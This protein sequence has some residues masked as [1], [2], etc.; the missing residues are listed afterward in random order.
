MAEA[1]AARAA[2]LHRGLPDEITTWEILVRLP[3][4]ALLRCRATSAPPP[5]ARQASLPLL[6]GTDRHSLFAFDHR[7]AAA[8]QLQPVARLRL[9]DSCDGLLVLHNLGTPGL[10]YSIFNPATRQYASL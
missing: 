10:S 1:A 9:S 5:H 2:P 8:E 7:P 6:D 4:T 3:P